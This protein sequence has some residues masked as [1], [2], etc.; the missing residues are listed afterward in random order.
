MGKGM[1]IVLNGVSSAGKT[2][3][4]KKIQEK[5]DGNL[6]WISVDT[7]CNMWPEKIFEGDFTETYLRIQ[8]IMFRSIKLFADSGTDVVLDCVLLKPY[9]ALEELILLLQNYS[10]LLVRVN[11]SLEELRR[12]ETERG[13]REP[14]Q[15]ESQ[16]P[17]LVPADTYDLTVDTSLSA[18]DDCADKIIEL[19]KNPDRWSAFS[20]LSA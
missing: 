15:A 20:E 19:S 8:T 13:D 18:I 9:H 6:A 2:T 3:L 17:Y 11:C 7:F 16:L 14:G 12:R 5:S 1:I 4:A 10:I